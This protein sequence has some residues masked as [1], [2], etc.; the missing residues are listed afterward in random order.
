MD[1]D[2]LM[3]MSKLHWRLPPMRAR[4]NSAQRLVRALLR[5]TERPYVAY[6]GGKDSQ[7][8]VD[9]VLRIRP[10]V[11]VVFHDEDWLPPGT[12]EVV[13]ATEKHYGIHILR[14]RERRSADEFFA[15]FGTWPTCS[16]PR[17][18]DFE[19]DTWGE[20]VGHYGFDGVAMGL[21]A[22]ES[23]GRRFALRKPLR[24]TQDGLWHC[25]PLHDWSA[26]EV[27]AYL[28]GNELPIHP[29]YAQMINAGMP[30]ERARIGPLTAVRVYQYGLL[31]TTRH[32]WPELWNAFV[33]DNPVV[34][35]F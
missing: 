31:E 1:Y 4:V 10:E 16:N 17:P 29:A 15:E 33:T 27:F 26:P 19:A 14:V 5:R 11:Q 2:T 3:A 7:C 28:V 32:L 12:L 23:T 20:I 35:N 18:V 34:A 13:E 30:I 24:K 6:S 21:R 9:I 22:E 8:L 25:S